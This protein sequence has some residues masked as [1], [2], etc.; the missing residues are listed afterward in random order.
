MYVAGEASA[1]ESIKDPRSMPPKPDS[2]EKM[3]R[4]TVSMWGIFLYLHKRDSKLEE[5]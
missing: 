2:S 5:Y 4:D 3:A 1:F